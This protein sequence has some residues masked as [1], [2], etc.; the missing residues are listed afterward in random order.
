M[1]IEDKWE[2]VSTPTSPILSGYSSIGRALRYQEV[3][4]SN[5][6]TPIFALMVKFS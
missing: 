5:P 6:S 4:G 3:V 2:D 1:Y